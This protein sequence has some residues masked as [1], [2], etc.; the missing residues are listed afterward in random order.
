MSSSTGFAADA[1][2]G[3]PG[4]GADEIPVDKPPGVCFLSTEESL[5]ERRTAC[6][7]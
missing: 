4:S 1:E 6:N 5:H 7:E 2:R 3:Q